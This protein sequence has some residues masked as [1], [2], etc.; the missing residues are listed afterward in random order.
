MMG[1]GT[2]TQSTAGT[3][4]LA[5]NDDVHG[6]SHENIVI[7]SSNDVLPLRRLQLEQYHI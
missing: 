4:G 5:S 3:S 1:E 6:L 2:M 7:I